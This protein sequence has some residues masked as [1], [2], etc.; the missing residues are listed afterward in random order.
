MSTDNLLVGAAK[1]DI[2]P[3][4]HV[5]YLAFEPERQ[6]T[7][8]GVHDSLYARAAVFD[9]GECRIGLLTADVLGL[10]PDLLGPGTDF[11]AEVR[12]LVAAG[13]G[14]CPEE[15]MLTAAHPHSTPETYGLTRIWERDD[16][17]PW[18]RTFAEQLAQTLTD[19]WEGRSPAQLRHGTARVPGLGCNR[20]A[21]VGG[22]AYDHPVDDSV[23]ALVAEREGAPPVVVANFACH[24]V[25]VQVQPLVSADFPGVACDTVERA[26]AGSTGEPAHCLF[27][28]GAAGDVD[29][30]RGGSGS[31]DDVT[32]YGRLLAGGILEAVGASMLSKPDAAPR[33]SAAREVLSLASRSV[34]SLEAAVASKERAEH[35]FEGMPDTHPEY[36]VRLHDLRWAREAHRRALLGPGP[37]NAEVQVLRI[38]DV[39]VA[40]VPGELFSSLGLLIKHHSPAPAT[41]V[42]ELAN[43][44]LGYLA[45]RRD[46]GH[47][48]YE[49]APGPWCR[50][51]PGGPEHV[52]DTACRLVYGVFA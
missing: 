42:A 51:A 43:G 45:P 20:R 16:C 29:P 21:H 34:P 7:F 3:P 39:A 2:T 35:A 38:G 11:I 4:L 40:G 5:P 8:E 49:V 31:W 50:I 14:L 32:A 22:D 15:I 1:R 12:R 26:L 30:V 41:M 47:G 44:C 17:Q 46:W 48:G 10:S 27:V 37:V 33:L 23:T 36:G 19:A 24:P 6:R 18:L 25:T 52:T 13:S 28:Q 9:T